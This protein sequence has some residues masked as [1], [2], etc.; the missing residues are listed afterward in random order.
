M[1]KFVSSIT[2][3]ML[4][5]ISFRKAADRWNDTYELNLLRFDKYCKAYFPNTA[6]LTQEMAD[7]W[8]R[9]RETETNNSCRARTAPI[10]AFI[11][12]LR[13]RGKTDISEPLVPRLERCTHIPHAFSETELSNFFRACDEIP[14]STEKTKRLRKLTVPV[15]FRLLYSSGIRTVEARML[16]AIDVDLDGGILNIRRSKGTSGHYVVLHDSM[17]ELMKQYDSAVGRICLNR[18]Y[19]FP[20]LRNSF[21]GQSGIERN[22]RLMW[23]KYNTTHA[24]P[25]DFRHNYAIENINSW[26]DD[27]FEFHAKLL[28]LSKS[29]G[30]SKLDSTRY[31]YNLVPGL[32]NILQTH[33]DGDMIIPEV[34]Y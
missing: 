4:E 29:M 34:G 19:F 24:I 13:E 12:F 15:F 6:E 17:L 8:C 10:T 18:V 25:Y 14:D 2:P 11:H 16:K 32:A 22:F 23:N 20:S 3:L 33:A 30:H 27:G 28:Y 7:G 26:T 9:K 21:C 5:Y 1:R 31:Y